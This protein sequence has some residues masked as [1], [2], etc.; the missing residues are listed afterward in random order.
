M[1]L[2]PSDYQQQLQ[3]LLPHGPAWPRDEDA[4]LTHLLQGLAKELARVDERANQL[5]EEADPRTSSELFGDWERAAGLPDACLTALEGSDSATQRRSALVGKITGL[6]GQSLQYYIELA[7]ALGYRIE[8]TEFHS[9]TVADDVQYPLYG[10]SWNFAWQVNTQVATQP[11]QNTLHRHSVNDPVNYPLY[12][13]AWNFDNFSGGFSE[14]T[15]D[16]AVDQAL[17]SWNNALLRCAF[18]RVAPAHTTVL[19]SYSER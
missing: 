11:L 15:V 5:A 17:A 7:K 16:S 2:N 6:G 8:I 18:N 13:A 4:S 12:D 19:Y 1:A 9:Q 10:L 14:F 3:A